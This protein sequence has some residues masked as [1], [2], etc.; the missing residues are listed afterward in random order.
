[1]AMIYYK[2]GVFQAQCFT[3]ALPAHSSKPHLTN[4]NS[5][6]YHKSTVSPKRI[7]KVKHKKRPKTRGSP[8]KSRDLRRIRKKMKRT[9]IVQLWPFLDV[10]FYHC[11]TRGK[12]RGKTLVKRTGK[13]N[14]L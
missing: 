4:S 11:F 8:I 13:T 6:T 7:T 14:I 5:N 12:I 2:I 9:I 1:M 3:T 10:L